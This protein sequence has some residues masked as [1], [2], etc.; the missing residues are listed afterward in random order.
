MKL[1]HE[2]ITSCFTD[3]KYMRGFSL[4]FHIIKYVG[5]EL[6]N[7][8]RLSSKSIVDTSINIGKRDIAIFPKGVNHFLGLVI[9]KCRKISVSAFRTIHNPAI[10]RI[11]T[12]LSVKG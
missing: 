2:V 1:A 6:T 3:L 4:R 9:S 12:L 11:I 8:P 5:T 10:H 7:G